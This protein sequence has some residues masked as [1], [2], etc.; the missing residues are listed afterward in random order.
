M[1]ALQEHY[2]ELLKLSRMYLLQEYAL[3]D[4]LLADKETYNYFCDFARKNPTNVVQ[5][6]KIQPSIPAAS[7]PKSSL[8]ET[9][10]PAKA[11]LNSSNP[12]TAQSL[13]KAEP[14]PNRVPVVVNEEPILIKEPKE[15]AGSIFVPELPPSAEA[16]DLS[17]IRKI[18]TQKHPSIHFLDAIPSDSEAKKKAKLWEQEQLSQIIILMFNEGLKHKHFLENLCMAVEVYGWN[19]KIVNG[20]DVEKNK[21]WETVLNSKKLKLVLATNK[22]IERFVNLKKLY[23][24]PIESGKPCTLAGTP[25]LLIAE[26]AAYV[27]EPQLKPMLWKDLKELLAKIS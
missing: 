12:L 21:K 16:V 7:I 22:D 18:L 4:R 6:K 24:E 10:V 8:P 19:I 13:T 2:T 27:S 20:E 17:E 25:V 23:R 1:K 3:N 9:V 11:K 26:P 15:K 5:S 14:A